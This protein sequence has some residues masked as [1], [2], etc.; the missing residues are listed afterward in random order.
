MPACLSWVITAEVASC[1]CVLASAAAPISCAP[2]AVRRLLQCSESFQNHFCKSLTSLGVLRQPGETGVL[3]MPPETAEQMADTV[4]HLEGKVPENCS[5]F[6][7]RLRDWL[8]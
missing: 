3:Y 8:K 5:T 2:C 1:L 7:S 6:Q 4:H